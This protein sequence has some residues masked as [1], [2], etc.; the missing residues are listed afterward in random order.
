MKYLYD[1][2]GDWY[3]AMA[4]YDHGAGNIQKAVARTGYASFWEL[5]QAARAA[6]RRH[7]TTFLKSSPR[8][9]SRT[10]RN[11]TGSTRL[12]SIRRC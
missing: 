10:I 4:A 1:Q 8:S 11:S 7:R 2:L 12:R 3:L 9:S 5:Y 6:R